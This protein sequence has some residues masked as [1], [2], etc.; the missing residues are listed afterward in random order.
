VRLHVLIPLISLS[1][2]VIAR[3]GRA[4]QTAPPTHETQRIK[5]HATLAMLPRTEP[6]D[7]RINRVTALHR[8]EKVVRGEYA[9]RTILV[10]HRCP[11]IPRGPSRFGRGDAGA[12]RPGKIH[13]LTLEPRD[14]ASTLKVTDPFTDDKRPRWDALRTD[15]SVWPPKIVVVVEGG[16]GT[17]L[18]LEFDTD[19][20][21]V[22]RAVDADIKLLGAGVSLRHLRIGVQ[23][24][25]IEVSPVGDAVTLRRKGKNKKNT[26][27]AKPTRITF[28]D[29]LAIGEYTLRIALFL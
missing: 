10:V 16:G 12:L 19:H 24:D 7:G 6:C 29:R 9:D 14:P 13:L 3:G 27:L 23:G 5:L 25:K 11:E 17:R 20:L 1:S 4:E 22:G 26:R 18:K 2:I 15:K 8:V 28:Q 21:T